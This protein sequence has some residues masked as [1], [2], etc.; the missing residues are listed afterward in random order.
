MS[1][2]FTRRH[3]LSR[4][5]AGGAG[6][7]AAPAWATAPLESIRP[8]SRPADLL[9]PPKGADLVKRAGIEGHVAFVVADAMTGELLDSLDAAEAVP[10]ASVG[11]TLTALYALRSLGADHRFTTQ[12]LAT[13][14]IRNG[15]LEGDLV[16]VGG[17]DPTLDTDGLADLAAAAKETGLVEVTGRFLVYGGALPSAVQ[18][19][20][21]QPPH[22]GYNPAV[23]GIA[24]N[25]N[26]VHFEW[27]RESG[28]YTI[29]M[30]ARS[31]RYRPDVT[32]ATMRV[33][34]RSLPVYTYDDVDGVDRWS[35]A[36]GAL[37][38]GGA[39][40]LPVRKPEAYAGEVMQVLLRAHGIVAK[41]PTVTQSLPQGTV[42]AQKQSG[43]LRE[44]I[45]DMLKYSTNLTAEMIGLAASKA[46]YGEVASMRDSAEKMSD[47][48]KQTL[49]LRHVAMEDHSGLGDDSRVTAADMVLVMVQARQQDALRPLLKHIPVKDGRGRP[50]PKA[51]MTVV[52]KTGTLNF[53]SGLSGFAEVEGRLLAFAIF[54]ADIAHRDR[55]TMAE[56]ERPAGGRAWLAR[57]RQLQQDLL[58]FWGRT[59]SGQG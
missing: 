10:P 8:K 23:S 48:A 32:M 17:G 20:P 33:E 37:G 38:T 46:R 3:F 43:P 30:D 42:F 44:I 54:C 39:R 27:R 41:A 35:V 29:T 56:R 34:D 13:G 19:D 57:A 21:E 24:L 2:G 11:K 1:M 4:L 58:Q 12:L 28:D 15:R 7:T 51:A 22:V 55:L 26:R 59:Y 49:G 9:E 40:W 36:K 47:W 52:A 14:P 25:F 5:A 50:D 6:L 16:L 45:L 31:G 53:V 18:I